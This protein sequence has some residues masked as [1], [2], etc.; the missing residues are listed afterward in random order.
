[1]PDGDRFER[2]LRGKGWAGVYRLGCSSA[3]NEAV[4]DKM[5]GAVAHLFRTQDTRIIRDTHRELEDAC[6]LLTTARLRES[7]SQQAFDQLASAAT[8]LKEDAG[9]SEL[10]RFAE[11]A[12]LRTFNEIDKSGERWNEDALKQRFTRNLV[13]ELSE[14]R[15]FAVTREGI[16]ESTRRDRESQLG[17]EAKIREL[18]LVPCA[19]LSKNLISE[20]ASPLVRAPKHLFQPKP[21]TLET[22]TTP[23]QVL[24]TSQ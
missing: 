16:M 20:E 23:L 22:L 3:P 19:A 5:M 18:L 11:R 24:G 1:M 10:A 8:A 12:A 4:V 17:W 15:C 14:R 6:Q 2:R 21:M 7:V 13:W 9:F